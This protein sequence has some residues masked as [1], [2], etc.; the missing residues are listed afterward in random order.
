MSENLYLSS[1]ELEEIFKKHIRTNVYNY[2]IKTLFAPRLINRV[3]YSPYYQRNY[4]WDTVKATFFIESILLGTDIPPLILFNNGSNLEVIDGRQ[5]YETIKKFKNN[6]LKLAI[7]GL[8]VL[9]QLK[10]MTFSK[11]DSRIQD[12]FDDTKIRIF[13]FEII[14]E[15]KLDS[16]L[17]DK[18]KKEIFRRYNSGITPLSRAELDNA[19]YDDDEVTNSLKLILQ[20]N[21]D[22]FLLLTKYFQPRSQ[23]DKAT[24]ITSI[25]QSLRKYLVFTSLPINIY[26][27]GKKRTEFIELLYNI[28][29]TSTDNIDELSNFLL[30]NITYSIDF[31]EK[32]NLTRFDNRYLNECILWGITILRESDIDISILFNKQNLSKTNTFINEHINDFNTEGSHY[33]SPIVL[34]FQTIT[35]LFNEF[36]DFNFSS[37]FKNDTFKN[38]IDANGQKKEDTILKIDELSSLRVNKPEPS[39]IPIDEI[40]N[41]L[42]SKRYM[43]RPS[44]QRQEKININKASAIIESI[45]LGI[46][47]PPIFIYKNEDG[48]KEVIDGQQ[49]LLSILSFLGKQYRNENDK[50]IYSKNNSYKLKRLKILREYDNYSFNDLELSLQDKILDFCLSVIE[51]DS[52]INNNFDPVDL[53]IRLNYK[54]YPIKDNSFEMWN[55]YIDKEIIKKIKT[56]T[57]KN[58]SWFFITQRKKNSDRMIN[59]ELITLLSYIQFNRKYKNDMNSIGYYERNNQAK[60]RIRDKKEVTTLLEKISSDEL[61]KKYFMQSIEILEAKIDKLC[62]KLDRDNLK[63]SLH[64]LLN[65]EPRSYQRYLIDFYLLFEVIVRLDN[66][67]FENITFNE[68]QQKLLLVQNEL[69]NP[70]NRDRNLQ[71]HVIS[72][73]DNNI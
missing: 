62:E 12:L 56:L 8:H 3:D 37:Y 28:K 54:P 35:K 73:L 71:E 31:I 65:K 51:I 42:I 49:R 68:L 39:L 55:S 27:A 44:Y 11:L 63:N 2:S 21:D 26:A 53:F 60:C 64:D 1:E 66:E 36:F 46:N 67:S 57:D 23:S 34:R 69:K 7:N 17:E 58:I 47:L 10:G 25:L 38:K 59:E 4:I 48:I 6:E 24:K 72:F 45:L 30:D 22:I 20:D 15:P 50:L 9:P 16:I 33:Y 43:I 61:L 41:D 19:T 5:R 32:S 13:D 18:V 14:N 70:T 40:M 52:R 29:C